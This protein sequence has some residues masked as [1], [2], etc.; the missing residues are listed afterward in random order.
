[1]QSSNIS[2]I[3]PENYRLQSEPSPYADPSSELGRDEFMRLLVAQLENQ[4]PLE[5]KQDTEFI[6]QLATY[7]SLEQLIDLNKRMDRMIVAQD[8]L[9]NGQALELVGREVLADTNGSLQLRRNGAE[10]VMFDLFEQPS[11]LTVEVYD[12]G[13]ALVRRVEIND[14]AP[15]RQRF[16]WDGRDNDGKELPPGEY[17]YRIYAKD[18]K[19]ESMSVRSIVAMPVEGL[20]VAEDGLFLVSGDR[21]IAFSQIAEIRRPETE[22]NSSHGKNESSSEPTQ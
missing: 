11:S 4:D 18:S 8:Q 9:L 5:P 6:A 22:A 14:L 19:G 15:G 3:S 1:M 10:S 13:N 17:R 2:S 20:R 7:S 21:V 12:E 16:E